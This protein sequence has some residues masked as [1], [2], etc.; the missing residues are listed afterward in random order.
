MA[1]G[2]LY[3]H[4]DDIA[5]QIRALCQAGGNTAAMVHQFIAECERQG[6]QPD[7]L[8]L[9]EKLNLYEQGYRDALGAVAVAF[10]ILPE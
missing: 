4:R 7:M 10:G 5:A 9:A 3:F 6:S 8:E 2:I 1:S